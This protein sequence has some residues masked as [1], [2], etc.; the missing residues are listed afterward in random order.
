VTLVGVERHRKESEIL[1]PECFV[2]ALLQDGCF[3]M[4]ASRFVFL[5]EP[6]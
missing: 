2:E 5:T 4:K 3:L 6:P 1:D